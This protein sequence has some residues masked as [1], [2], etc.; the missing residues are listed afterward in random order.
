MMSPYHPRV[1]FVFFVCA[2]LFFV[3]CSG[4]F[5]EDSSSEKTP[6]T[7]GEYLTK[8]VADIA[9]EKASDY[10]KGKVREKVEKKAPEVINAAYKKYPV[11]AKFTGSKDFSALMQDYDRYSNAYGKLSTLN[12]LLE[13]IA[14]GDTGA[15]AYA[16]VKEIITNLFPPAKYIYGYAEA[17]NKV[18]TSVSDAV[19]KNNLDYIRKE[20]Y[21]DV[22]SKC[23]EDC[24]RADEEAFARNMGE[25][26]LTD[27]GEYG[28]VAW[29]CKE[30][31]AAALPKCGS[32]CV[33]GPF[34]W[35]KRRSFENSGCEPYAVMSFIRMDPAIRGAV[36]LHHQL[37]QAIEDVGDMRKA[38]EEAQAYV[39]KNLLLF[40][41]EQEK[42][43][44]AREN[45]Q[46]E[47]KKASGERVAVA[48]RPEK[49]DESC[50]RQIRSALERYDTLGKEIDDRRA[51]ILRREKE[52]GREMFT[53][54][55]ELKYTFPSDVKLDPG[56]PVIDEEQVD[57]N[58]RQVE[59]LDRLIG[60]TEKWLQIRPMQIGIYDARISGLQGLAGLYQERQNLMMRYGDSFCIVR[61]SCRYD[62]TVT[63]NAP[64]MLEAEIR[65]VEIQKQE[66][67]DEVSLIQTNLAG[68]KKLKDQYQRAFDGGLRRA[69]ETLDKEIEPAFRE[70]EKAS[71]EFESIE[72]DIRVC[73]Q[74]K[75]V[76][77]NV[78]LERIRS[79]KGLV[80][81]DTVNAQSQKDMAEY[82]RLRQRQIQLAAKIDDQK[83]KIESISRT[84]KIQRSSRSLGYQNK[85]VFSRNA[86][87]DL[88]GSRFSL[89]DYL[90]YFAEANRYVADACAQNYGQAM[91]MMP[92]DEL[93]MIV[94]PDQEIRK[95]QVALHE[96]TGEAAVSSIR[97][98][99]AAKARI[100]EFNGA[101]SAYQTDLGSHIHYGDWKIDSVLSQEAR[102]ALNRLSSFSDR[103][104]RPL[105]E[106]RS[107]K[108]KEKVTYGLPEIGQ[109][110]QTLHGAVRLRDTD[111]RDGF[112]PFR[113]P[114]SGWGIAGAVVSVS[115]Q[116]QNLPLK[117]ATSMAEGRPTAVYTAMISVK[118]K[119][120]VEVSYTVGNWTYA[121]V[122]HPPAGASLSQEKIRKIK[123]FYEKFRQAYEA[124]N[125]SQVMA[126]LSDS[127]QAGDGTT[128]ADLRDNLR[129][130]FRMFDEI[131]YDIKNLS[132]TS[133]EH[134]LYSVSYDVFISS[135]MYKRNLKHEEKSSIQEEVGI[136]KSGK[137]KIKKTLGGRFWQVQ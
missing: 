136:N 122:L 67:L 112:V 65:E 79:A 95:L 41:Q 128:I 117:I 24:S 40:E 12:G 31:G 22:L 1:S 8:K 64:R 111:V 42:N 46:G 101:Y 89:S 10:I 3:T 58:G 66:A 129:R 108:M 73:E 123:D 88:S 126:M 125:E 52:L 78:V 124:R 77:I 45:L 118:N 137:V 4:A 19:E 105:L 81:I 90:K 72:E 5:A 100:K 104:L 127:W 119:K 87:A 93:K 59:S 17:M 94:M 91:K 61:Q 2:W 43:L 20:F 32:I 86:R 120:D 92:A 132:V 75:L 51:A 56:E 49:C 109:G 21:R 84:K 38:L 63:V 103:H 29:Y 28:L 131:R 69:K 26:M 54:N 133:E 33:S 16:A 15:A 121:L 57:F 106:K 85:S 102:E 50:D 11:I 25:R 96:L 110:A 37:R 13:Q 74:E 116:G 48:K 62:L 99:A 130:T 44:T 30:G 34:D 76:Q 113:I 9:N 23:R 14:A 97:N 6:Q 53:K 18:L 36:T 55:S 115:A 39:K 71:R 107:A 135:R 98:R 35:S 7:T 114:V 27:G 70:Y 47:K 82:E 80:D 134:G 68:Y 83:N 60:N